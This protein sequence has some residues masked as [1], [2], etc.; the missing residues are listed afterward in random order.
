MGCIHPLSS[1]PATP[2]MMIQEYLYGSKHSD[3]F[4]LKKN[5]NQFH[6]PKVILVAFMLAA[7]MLSEFAFS[8]PGSFPKIH[9][10]RRSRE[11]LMFSS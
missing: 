2:K 8:K 10:G 9:S 3:M 7:F 6:F 4:D 1:I 5:K 11:G